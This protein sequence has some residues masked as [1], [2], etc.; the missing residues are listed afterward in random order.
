MHASACFLSQFS[1]KNVAI[2]KSKSI[3]VLVNK[4]ES[5]HRPGNPSDSW[6]AEPRCENPEK[7]GCHGRRVV[8][9]ARGVVPER[10]APGKPARQ[11]GAPSHCQLTGRGAQS[12]R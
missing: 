3:I 7:E 11:A 8:L 5:D 4:V 12:G 9:E 1:R 10:P 2:F 6:K